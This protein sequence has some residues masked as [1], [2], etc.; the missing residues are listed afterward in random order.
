MDGVFFDE[1]VFDYNPAT[2]N[3]MSNI[4]TLVR[5]SITRSKATVVFNPGL[6]VAS[7]WYNIADYIV[8]FEDT[9]TAY[10]STIISQID[11]RLRGKSLFIIYGY[12]GTV[13]QMK[14]LVRDI[15]GG[16][17]GGLWISDLSVYDAWTS[18]W[19]VFAETMNSA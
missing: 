12:K 4:T 8:A 16:M 19:A 14:T 9:W 7:E 3:Y 6:V 11:Q 13:E 10:Q 17:I 18:M 2:Q 5:N 15:I 1:A